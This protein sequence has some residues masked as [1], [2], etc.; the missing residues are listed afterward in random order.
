MGE[1]DIDKYFKDQLN[2]HSKKVDTD[3]IWA[4]IDLEDD[5]KEKSFIVWF[6]GLFLIMFLGAIYLA[7][8]KLF[9][10][11]DFATSTEAAI[12]ASP[13][14]STTS[15]YKSNE[16]KVKANKPAQQEIRKNKASNPENK[17]KVI[18]PAPTVW[19][20]NDNTTSQK[21][22]IPPAA[23]NDSHSET[24]ITDINQKTK[25]IAATRHL[26]SE[27]ILNK[28]KVNI[29]EKDEALKSAVDINS[30]SQNTGNTSFPIQLTTLAILET[31]S[32]NPFYIPER[33]KP[34]PEL[35]E[36]IALPEIVELNENKRKSVSLDL[37]SGVYK[38]D[39]T[40]TQV[41]PAVNSL[42]S[43]KESTETP[44]ELISLGAQIK[45]DLGA[46]YFKTGLE[47]QSLNERF[48]HEKFEVLDTVTT[49]GVIALN[50][51]T[52]RDTTSQMGPTLNENTLTTRWKQYNNHRL[53]SVPFSIGYEKEL[54]RWTWSVEATALVNVYHDFSGKQLAED[55]SITD[56]KDSLNDSVKFGYGISTAVLFRL[57]EN[58]SIYL[59]PH[60][61]QYNDSFVKN[62]A[63]YK[64]KYRMYG[65]KLG[66][67]YTW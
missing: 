55:E 58:T 57:T 26:I 20:I 56:L 42:L 23:V 13:P 45:Y 54:K 14:Q 31:K 12:Q 28:P 52:E 47:F 5:K 30:K 9:S 22:T 16:P 43:K 60:Y 61:F 49:Q 1:H 48:E 2:G 37:Y 51:S 46:L 33:T 24:T 64:Q 27:S 19:E 36:P 34:N 44:L 18:T 15:K 66:V 29:E 63:G 3:A 67:N 10:L 11:Q 4:G 8:D 41:D 39:R 6:K 21:A 65:G 25:K 17:S 35:V 53:F 50:V 62:A 7:S 32:V 59:S 38:L 40:L